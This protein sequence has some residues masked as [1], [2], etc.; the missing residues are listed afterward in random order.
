[1]NYN[2]TKEWM[3]RVQRDYESITL[4]TAW[5]R[6]A[7][8]AKNHERTDL[9]PIFFIPGFRTCGI[10][11][12]INGTLSSLYDNYR[13]YLLDVLGQPGLSHHHAPSVRSIDYGLWLR[14]VLDHLELETVNVAGV[15]FGGFLVFKLAQVANDRIQRAFVCNPVG[16]RMIRVNWTIAYYNALPYLSTTNKSIQQFLEKVIINDPKI[17][18]GQTRQHIVEYIKNTIKYDQLRTD[19]PYRYSDR[20]LQALQA[21]THLIVDA[22]DTFINQVA[23]QKRAKK[24]LPNLKGIHQVKGVGHGLEFVEAPILYM[25]SVI[26]GK[27]E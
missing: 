2:W 9:T 11:W 27:G 12:D 17:L 1:M 15:S 10:F 25:K 19:Y 21:E 4:E 20:E 16:L 3:K 14:E 26:E 8:L 5:G 7:L 6:T 24:V 13:I 23:T 18:E 22:E